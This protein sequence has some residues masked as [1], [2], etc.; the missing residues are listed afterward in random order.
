MEYKIHHHWPEN[1][2]EAIEIQKKLAEKIQIDGNYDDIKLIA[3]VDTA[4]GKNADL[5][6]AA[7][8]LVTFPE[9]EEVERTFQYEP[10][11]FPY[12]PGYFYFREGHVIINTLAKLKCEPDIIIVHGHGI[13]HPRRCGIAS[14]IGLAFDKPSIGCARKLL[15]G[16]LRQ[17]SPTKGSYQPII[18]NSKEVGIAYRS[19]DNV[20]PIFISPGYKCNLNQSKDIIVKNLRG[21]RLPEPL[22]IAHLIANKFK[23]HIENK[24]LVSSSQS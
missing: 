7:S 17:V 21:F 5:I 6:F 15:T 13:A 20:K 1:K 3:A 16:N 14:L 2:F 24:E 22:R 10:V 18:L 12:I 19:K 8:V 23:R 11:N 4:Y 9:I